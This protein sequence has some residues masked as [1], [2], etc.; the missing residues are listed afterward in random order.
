M[1]EHD[2]KKSGYCDPFIEGCECKMCR[3]YGEAVEHAA[4]HIR[5]YIDNQI[6]SNIRQEALTGA[7]PNRR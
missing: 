1:S 3:D 4:E 6:L 5:E 2:W 7:N